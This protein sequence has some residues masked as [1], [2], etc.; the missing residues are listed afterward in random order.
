[1]EKKINLSVMDKEVYWKN[2]I[3]EWKN[4]GL[5]Q[6]EFCQQNK[7]AQSNFFNWRKRLQE[8]G[9]DLPR[10]LLAPVSIKQEEPKRVKPTF[11][12]AP[13][14]LLLKNQVR[15]E[16]TA[17]TDKLALKR[18]LEVLGVLPC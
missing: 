5:S 16:I 6:A 7:I 2:L 18:L 14:V 3:K 9:V 1:M 17:H 11:S 4:S 15:L 12:S 10:V 13:I 8:K